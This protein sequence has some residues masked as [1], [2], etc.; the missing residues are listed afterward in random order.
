MISQ[1]C[2]VDD[3]CKAFYNEITKSQL[4][5]NYR[6]PTRVPGITNS[7]IITILLTFQTSHMKNFKHFYLRCREEYLDE[8]PHMPT[9][10]RF[11]TLKP[12][13]VPI[14]TALFMSLRKND[15]D[16][17]FVDSTPIKVCKNK[18]IFTHKVFKGLTE[19]EKSTMGCF[20]G[21]NFISLSMKKERL[22]MHN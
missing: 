7:E 20:F 19:R 18:R 2:F 21:L 16:I 4:P 8:F 6:K 12:R 3:F 11:L 13:V 14:L 22:L 5:Q 17:A 15:S 1:S 9:Y 10:E